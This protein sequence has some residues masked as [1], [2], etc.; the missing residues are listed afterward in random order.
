[1]SNPTKRKVDDDLEDSGGQ[2]LNYVWQEPPKKKQNSNKK[3]PG[4]DNSNNIQF[5][6]ALSL[7]TL[8]QVYQLCSAK[9]LS[10]ETKLKD[11]TKIITES[12]LLKKMVIPKPESKLGGKSSGASSSSGS[13]KS[14]K[15][16]KKA[17]GEEAKEEG[18]K[19]KAKKGS[20]R[21]T[22]EERKAYLKREKIL[23]LAYCQYC[24]N[25]CCFQHYPNIYEDPDL[26][27]Y[28]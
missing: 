11:I 16:K 8:K 21:M 26:E 18:T 5:S 3:C 9:N 25:G 19:K 27:G 10:Q 24:D 23:N 28:V 2:P 12:E 17:T 4:E 7:K 13:S 1:M 14:L 15:N 6:D 20:S 22:P